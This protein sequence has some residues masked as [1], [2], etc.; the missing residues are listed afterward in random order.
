M[1]SQKH[2]IIINGPARSGKDTFVMYCKQ[3]AEE[4]SLTLS[5]ISSVDGV[6]EYLQKNSNTD[7]LF[8]DGVT[9]DEYRRKQM[10]DLKQKRIKQDPLSI[11]HRVLQKIQEIN[12][13]LNFIH[14]REPEEIEKMKKAGI[15]S[16]YRV[17]TLHIS[18]PEIQ[19]Y[20]NGIDDQTENYTYDTYIKNNQ[21]L[22]HLKLL[23]REYI[24]NLL[25]N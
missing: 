21:D 18:K 1:S 15:Q 13:D 24:T 5:N 9:K 7:G 25:K 8:R 4:I 6:K 19:R 22:T 23:A 20:T 2:L 11:T 3:V 10:I 12:A 16:G 17:S 14:I